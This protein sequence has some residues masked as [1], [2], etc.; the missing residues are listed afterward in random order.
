MFPIYFGKTSYLRANINAPK[1]QG[2]YCLA[3]ILCMA[4]SCFLLMS[5]VPGAESLALSAKSDTGSV[6]GSI[7]DVACIMV[8]L[9]CNGSGTT[10]ACQYCTM[11]QEDMS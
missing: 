9:A 11:G 5:L 8:N 2:Q 7:A 1:R 10:T 3:V 6:L 4:V